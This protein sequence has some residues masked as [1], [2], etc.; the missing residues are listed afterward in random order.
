MERRYPRESK[1]STSFD[2]FFSLFF[3]RNLDFGLDNLDEVKEK[4][5]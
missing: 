3:V 1:P 2:Q 4:I 5:V